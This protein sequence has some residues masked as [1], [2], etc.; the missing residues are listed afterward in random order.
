VAEAQGLLDRLARAPALFALALGVRAAYFAWTGTAPAAL[1]HPDSQLFVELAQSPG[2]WTGH[3]ER[4]P[5]YPIFLRLH[6]IVFGSGAFWAPV[7]TQFVVDA[8]SCIAIARTAELLK[9]GAGRWAGL[10]AAFNPTQIV[11]AGVLLGDSL[12]MACIAGGL[13]A[14]AR[15]WHAPAAARAGAAFRTGCW[16]GLGL[17]NRAVIWP[18]VP[19]LAFVMLL[20]RGIRAPDWRSAAIAACTIAACA[21]PVI[22]HNWVAYGKPALSAQGGVHMAKW[23]YP[24]VREAADGTP[25]ATTLDAVSAEFDARGGV[26]DREN[27]FGNEAIYA[28]IARDGLA[29]VGPVGIVKAWIFGAAINLASPATLMIPKVMALPHAG[30][31]MT[32]GAGPIEK[33]VNFLRESLGQ[34]YLAWLAGG[35]AVEWPLHF[36]AVVGVLVALR[37]RDI[38]PAALFAILW[39]GYVLAIQGPVASA[40][41][42]LPIEPVCM[43][44]AALALSRPKA[45]P[46]FSRS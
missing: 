19:V 13:L 32:Q 44:F 15:W 35:V 1:F 37:R 18:F 43:V 21:A 36:L 17:L 24:L 25:Y 34:P 40:K 33:A 11:I 14:L 22:A 2:W 42:R 10:F 6:F 46:G 28:G 39:I 31:Y 27:W 26:R 38:R 20:A 29:A 7:A 30:F 45:D 3:P 4:M 5:A 41:Y 16:L 12:Y 23:W 8:L 9:T